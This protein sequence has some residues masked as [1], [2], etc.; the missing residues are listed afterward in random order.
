[1]SD[2]Q[3]MITSLFRARADVVGILSLERFGRES[4]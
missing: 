1:M 4:H 3:E 2:I